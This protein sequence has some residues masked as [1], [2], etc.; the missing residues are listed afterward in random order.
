MKL[1][2]LVAAALV[3]GALA[4]PA[5]QASAPLHCGAT[6]TKSTKL[7]QDRTNCPGVGIQIGADASPST[8][9][10]TPWR[11][12]PSAIPRRTASSTSATTA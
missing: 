6:I 2:P 3:A 4:A 10:A 12:R 9:T 1:P 8:S 5:S 7:T 11:P